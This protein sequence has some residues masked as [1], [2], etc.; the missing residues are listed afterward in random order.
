MKHP[1]VTELKRG[2]G[3]NRALCVFLLLSVIFGSG[4]VAHAQYKLTPPQIEVF[5]N[6]SEGNR[7][8][9]LVDRAKGGQA[10]LVEA[11]LTRFPLQGPHA[12]NRTT[13]IRGLLLAAKGDLTGA[14]KNYRA[15]L[16]DDPKL[17][18]VRSELIQTLLKLDENDSAKHHLQLMEADAPNEVVANRIK[19]FIDTIDAKRPFTLNGFMSIAPSTNINS[20]SNHDK[21]TTL[22]SDFSSNPELDITGSK[23][24][25]G[26][27]M[28]AG[29]SVGFSKRL[30][31]DW[32]AVFAGSLSG[33]V[34]SD[35]SFN[36]AQFSESAE[37][38]YHIDRGYIGFGA[39]ADQSI[40]PLAPDPL[41]PNPVNIG[42]NYHSYGP[43]VSLRYN[44]GQR[45]SLATSAVYEWRDYANST[46]LDGTALLTDFSWSHAFDSS[47]N[48]A[49]AGGYT[50]VN[51]NE[52]MVS[53]GT[54]FGGF[55][56]YKEL[57]LGITV[58][59]NA[60][61]LVSDFDAENII[62]GKTRHDTRYVGSL[63]LT[64][65]DFNILGFAP[66]VNYTYTLNNSN[67]E[68][69][70]YDSH[71]FDLRFTKDF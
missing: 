57:P 11:L 17:T 9:F 48:V 7:V 28:S 1:K 43:R 23:K 53:Y 52:A 34:Y 15:V 67:I 13:F 46:Y 68:L 45:D 56:V 20:G 66:S 5:T 42:I 25:S 38:R 41:N 32:E 26:I 54:V 27:G 18:L 55:S 36:S 19:A 2:R 3:K 24:Q 47:L 71:E 10:D 14:A 61:I 22:N 30:G 62:A 70:D 4:S 44:L 64:K 51:S 39:V 49:I 63:T 60:Q 21:V 59:T 29:M 40:V 37:M 8:R 33:S 69:W 65:R 50:K 58:N 16:A 35:P 12:P 6:A 31:N